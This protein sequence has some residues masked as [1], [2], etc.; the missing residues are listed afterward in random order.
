MLDLW[1][2]QQK[3][4]YHLQ[5]V[6][7]KGCHFLF[8]PHFGTS[9]YSSSQNFIQTELKKCLKTLLST[10]LTKWFIINKVKFR[11]ASVSSI[12]KYFLQSLNLII[13]NCLPNLTSCLNF[14][15]DFHF[16]AIFVSSKQRSILAHFLS[17]IFCLIFLNLSLQL[18]IWDYS[19][20]LAISDITFPFKAFSSPNL[21]STKQSSPD[22]LYVLI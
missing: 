21:H 2:L 13:G 1:W 16:S 3:E 6:S 7:F 5:T 9:M 18:L 10:L 19:L 22:C 17:Q 20:S 14:I 8:K 15:I 12:S 11:S 4:S